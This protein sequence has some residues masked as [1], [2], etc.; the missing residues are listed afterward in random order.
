MLRAAQAVA[1]AVVLVRLAPGSRPSRAT[2]PGG[3]EAARL[4]GH[5]GAR[6]GGADRAVPG[7]AAGDQGV[8]VIVVDDGSTDGTA[9]VARRAGRAGGRG[10]RRRPAGSASRGRCSR[11]SRRRGR[12]R[13]QLDADTRPRPGLAGAL[14]AALGDADLVTR[15]RAL[16]LRHAPASACCIRR[17]WRRSSTASGRPTRVARRAAGCWS[18]AS[19]RRS[20]RERLLAAGGYARAAGHMTDDAAQ[21]R[22]LARRGW[23]VAFHDAGDLLEVDMHDSGARRGANGGGRSRSPT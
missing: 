3:A 11:A 20:A 4:R 5:P 19:A 9:E 13:G 16:R 6:R 14:E 22:A 21:A 8:E 2:P 1:S 10:R 23:R 12:G 18:T 15:R 17:C 7:R